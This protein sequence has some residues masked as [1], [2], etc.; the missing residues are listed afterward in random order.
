M[1]DLPEPMRCQET[2]KARTAYQ[3]FFVVCKDADPD[4]PPPEA[5]KSGIRQT[6]PSLTTGAALAVGHGISYAGIHRQLV[7]IAVLRDE[8][9]QQ[10]ESVSPLPTISNPAAA[11]AHPVLISDE[12]RRS[13]RR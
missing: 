6:E 7:V 3:D 1:W 10:T 11:L 9:R 13:A 5:S 2:A 4:V 12:W 8:T